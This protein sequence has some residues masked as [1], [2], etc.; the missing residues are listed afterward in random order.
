MIKKIVTYEERV[1]RMKKP[2][3]E[4]REL[5]RAKNYVRMLE[6]KINKET[7][8]IKQRKLICLHRES[9]EVLCK[10]RR[11]IFELEDML[12]ALSV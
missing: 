7:D 10:L 6:R 4:H 11:N 1:A 5:I 9:K 3:D 2:G 8:E 12:I